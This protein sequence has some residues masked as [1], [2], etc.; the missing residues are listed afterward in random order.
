MQNKLLSREQKRTIL[1]SGVAGAAE[2]ASPHPMVSQPGAGRALMLGADQAFRIREWSNSPY[3]TKRGVVV[4]RNSYVSRNGEATMRTETS[5]VTQTQRMSVADS[6]PQAGDRALG[7]T[8]SKTMEFG[9]PVEAMVDFN[10]P[11]GRK[12]NA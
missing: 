9:N 10:G 11:V 12:Q 1:S 7:K 5:Q 6:V 2:F 4:R 8:E 3:S